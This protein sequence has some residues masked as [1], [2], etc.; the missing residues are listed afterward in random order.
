[1]AWLIGGL[2]VYVVGF[3]FYYFRV[4]RV[5]RALVDAQS[6]GRWWGFGLSFLLSSL[7]PLDFLPT[8]AW[9]YCV[10]WI[11]GLWIILF[12]IFMK[13]A[14]EWITRPIANRINRILFWMIFKM[15][16]LMAD[17]MNK[18]QS[19]SSL[20]KSNNSSGGKNSAS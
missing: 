17:E 18:S 15:D 9:N 6:G 14:P 7:W 12:R 13:Y 1:M 2:A 10:R 19:T 20:S 11:V 8:I 16:K 4:Y 5:P 3:L